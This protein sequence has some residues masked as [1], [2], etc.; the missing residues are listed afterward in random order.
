MTQLNRDFVLPAELLWKRSVCVFRPQSICVSCACRTWC[1]ATARRSVLS[2]STRWILSHRQ[3]RHS[4]CCVTVSC[5]VCCFLPLL[6]CD[7]IC[8]NR[9]SRRWSPARCSRTRR[10]TTHRA[11]P[12]CLSAR[13]SV[14]LRHNVFRL[15]FANCV[16]DSDSVS[17]PVQ[18][19]RTLTPKC[20]RPWA[21]RR[22]RL[23]EQSHRTKG[24]V[25]ALHKCFDRR[26]SVPSMQCQSPSTTG[27]ATRL[28]PASCCSLLTVPLS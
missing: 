5:L 4:L 1:G 8:L 23:V 11:C 21:V 7:Q 3:S 6:H 19:G 20:C 25:N 13:D 28:G 18:M 17:P 16:K 27:K 26:I 22:W 14:R 10:T 2:G 9:W 12:N 24:I 15:Q